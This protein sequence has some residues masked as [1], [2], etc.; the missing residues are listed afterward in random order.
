MYI[1]E[2]AI[3]VLSY[4]YLRRNHL[5]LKNELTHESSLTKK[6]NIFFHLSLPDKTRSVLKT[7]L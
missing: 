7:K 2:K 1:H 3:G 4:T 5:N 6:T